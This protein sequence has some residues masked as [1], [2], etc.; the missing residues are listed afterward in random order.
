MKP[1]E[2]YKYVVWIAIGWYKN[3][4]HFK[5]YWYAELGPVDMNQLYAF[6]YR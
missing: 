1:G 2:I 4:I 6:S 5:A 3:C